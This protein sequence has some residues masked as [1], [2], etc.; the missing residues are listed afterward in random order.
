MAYAVDVSGDAEL[1]AF[2][3]NA[4]LMRES[5]VAM[6]RENFDEFAEFVLR[7]EQSGET[8]EQAWLHEMWTYARTRHKR[9]L[10]ISHV[11]AG[12]SAQFSVGLPIHEIGLNV[13]TRIRVGSRTHK[14][15]MDNVRLGA[16]YIERS[17]E[18]REVFPHVIPG[19]KWSEAGYHVERPVAMRHASL[20]ALGMLGAVSGERIDGFIG[21]DLLDSTNTRTKI[22]RDEAEAWFFSEIYSR[23]DVDAFAYFVGNAWDPDDLYHRLEKRG[24]PTFRFPVVVTPELL[25]QWPTIALPPEQGGFGLKLGDPTWTKRWPKSRIKEQRKVLPPV[26]F[27]RSLMCLARSDADA[28]FKRAWI[29]KALEKGSDLP[30]CHT[31]EEF[32]AWDEGP[33]TYNEG[34]EDEERAAGNLVRMS[35]DPRKNQGGF[36]FYNG[37]DLSTG[38]SDDDSSIATI[39]VAVDTGKRFLLNLEAGKWQIDEIIRRI[40]DI[41]KRYGALFMIENN[42]VQQW[43]LQALKMGTAIPAVPFTTGKQKADPRTGVEVLAAELF[44][45]KWIFPSI[46]GEGATEDIQELCADMLQFNPHPRVHTGDRLMSLW[47][48]QVLASRM[49]RL[50]SRDERSQS[51]MTV[52]G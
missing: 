16:G 6:A 37:V 4:A 44:N 29:K 24:W 17:P 52:L 20:A 15:A 33:D 43:L 13:Q 22:R 35:L 27:D 28:R 21:D 1:Q 10:F 40:K 2:F 5:R 38:E 9:A 19:R 47:F 12:K 51:G 42:S 23:L 49:E 26:E 14:Q 48:A 31:R 11:E 7:D 50:E 30:V 39:A 45:E 8:I 3:D 46:D 34:L 25:K 36:R 32:L 18:Y 41:D